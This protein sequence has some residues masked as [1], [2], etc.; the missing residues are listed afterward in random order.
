MTEGLLNHLRGIRADV[1]SIQD[2]F[3]EI[4]SYDT[5]DFWTASSLVTVLKRN[6]MSKARKLLTKIE[7]DIGRLPKSFLSFDTSFDPNKGLI[8]DGLLNYS[9]KSDV[10]TAQAELVQLERAVDGQIERIIKQ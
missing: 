9:V 4:L 2:L 10:Q 3:Q 6:K 5:V 7:A 8:L 1:S